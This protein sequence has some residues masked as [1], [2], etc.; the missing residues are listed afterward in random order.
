MPATTAHNGGRLMHKA[1]AVI[2]TGGLSALA[3]ACARYIRARREQWLESAIDRKYGIDTC[4]IDDDLA[5]LGAA[6]AHLAQARGYEAIQAPVFRAILRA[7][8]IDPRTYVFIDFGSGKGRA[9]ILAAE[10]GFRRV[11]GIELAPALHE[12][13]QR[14]SEAFRRQ[15]PD[16]PPLEL[17]CGDAVGLTIPDADVLLFFC[18]PFGEGVMRKV[19]ANIE[20][21]HHRYARKVV[22]AYRNPVHWPVFEEMAFL[23]PVVRN[24]SFAVYRS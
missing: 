15:R 5:A 8:A 19:A 20:R 16:A 6:G 21:F 24:K 1:L 13:A 18:N 4:G 17:R 2:R 22:V 14:N 7:A 9:L 3:H 10:R 12:V 23:Q 11:I